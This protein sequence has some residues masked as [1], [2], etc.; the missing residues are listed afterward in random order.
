MR[1]PDQVQRIDFLGGEPLLVKEVGELLQ[2]LVDAGVA[3]NM[4]LAVVS[5][6]TVTGSWLGLT[7]HFKRVELC[8]S[9]DGHGRH[10]DYIRHPARWDKLTANLQAFKTLPNVSLG[11]AVTLQAY[12][13]LSLTDLF[14][15]FDSVDM[16]FHAWPIHVPRYLNVGVLPPRARQ[17]AAERLS[18]Y[19]ATD[20]KPWRRD[21]VQGLADYLQ[22]QR[23]RVRRAAGARLHALHERSRHHTQTDASSRS[24]PSWCG[25]MT[26]SAARGPARRCMRRRPARASARDCADDADCFLA[27]A[28]AD[29]AALRSWPASDLALASAAKSGRRSPPA[30]DG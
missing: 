9:V 11:A 6:G 7:R 4:V 15:Y 16:G 12:N 26:R 5:N 19:A 25:C 30:G 18:A 21:L 1:A 17:I 28:K 27:L 29:A 10:Y 20:C 8:I 2:R 14:R 3:R 13:A 22:Q 23:R 24:S